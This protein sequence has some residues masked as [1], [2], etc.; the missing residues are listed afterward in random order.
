MACKPILFGY[1]I[2]TRNLLVFLQKKAYP[3]GHISINIKKMQDLRKLE[4][5]LPDN[6]EVKDFYSV[7]FYLLTCKGD[8]NETTQPDD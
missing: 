5:Y 4:K 6:E 7:I 8:S 3:E 1:E 2:A